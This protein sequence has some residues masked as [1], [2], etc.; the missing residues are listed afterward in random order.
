MKKRTHAFDYGSVLKYALIF[1]GFV[2]FNKLEHDT[3][4]YSVALYATAM[5]M[6]CSLITT[7]LLLLGSFAVLGA[8]GLM[9]AAAVPAVFFI[10]VRLLYGKSKVKPSFEYVLFCA[11][12]MTGYLVVGDTG[13]QIPIEKRIIVSIIT[14]VLSLLGMIAFRALDKKGLRSKFGFEEKVAAAAMTVAAGL[15]ISNLFSPLVW[16]SVTVFLV[17]LCCYVYRF[18]LGSFIAAVF[19]ISLAVY[20]G[21]VEYIAVSLVFGI[22]ADTFMGVS[23]YLAALAVILS[24]Y[25]IELVFGVYGGYSVSEF[26]PVA[27]GAAAFCIIPFKFLKSVKERLSSFREKQLV[28]QTINRNR[29]MLSNKLYELSGV[30]T[31][32]SCA[33]T[34]FG[35]KQMTE[36]KAKAAFSEEI[37]LSVC[38]NCA[39]FTKCKR[40]EKDISAG[41]IKLL[42]IGFAKGKLSLID[43]PKD[44]GE[45]CVHPNDVIYGINKML[46]EYRAYTLE[47]ENVVNSREL[48]AAEASG[49]SEILR[50]LALESGATLKYQSKTERALAENLMK[51]GFNAS[52]LLIYGDDEK[53]SVSMILEAK[54][55]SVKQLY[56]IVNKT[57][58]TNMTLAEKYNITEEK[59]YLSF[60]RAADYDAV[61]GI[62]K[63]VKDGSDKSGDTHSVIRLGEEKFLVALSDGMGSGENAETVSS[64]SLSLIESFYRAGMG[65]DLILSTVN[66]LLSINT[67]DSFTALDVSV[68]DLKNCAADFIKYGAPYGYIVNSGAVR[69]VESNSLPLGILSDM[70]PSVCHANLSDGDM[71]VLV[72]DGISDAFGGSSEMIEFIRKEPALNPQTISDRI[73]EKAVELSGGTHKDDMT[74][75]AVRI[76]KKN[77]AA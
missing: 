30:F 68:I 15:G 71:I 48:L 38:K 70:T 74:V 5:F 37:K 16:K 2:L 27:I 23:G 4:P 46:A 55:F 47:N 22:V 72:T 76:F 33:F 66:K 51:K 41:L 12:S 26:L 42:D 19:G 24:D 40:A 64:V 59:F 50:D 6:N 7:P 31:E 62:S 65:S 54:E 10:F 25:V 35:K 53:L 11:I 28:R 39:N 52:E 67:E 8:F 34:A 14:V 18:G 32:M 44:V 45:H 73:M 63:A 57:L 29:L 49:V 43:L 1:F 61:F 58:G 36:D 75:L 21:N 20:Y 56:A 69:I 9:A 17:L 3:A 77:S 60:K 13:A